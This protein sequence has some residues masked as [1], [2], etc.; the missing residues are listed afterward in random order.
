MTGPDGELAWV[1]KMYRWLIEEDLSFREIADRLNEE[2]AT[3]DLDRPWNSSTVRTILSNEK[4]IGNN[5][6]SFKLKKLH[7]ENPLDMWVRK[8]GAFAG[9]VPLEIYLTARME[10]DAIRSYVTRH[11]SEFL[12]QFDLV[13]NTVSME[14]A[15]ER[16]ER[17]DGPSATQATVE[18][19]LAK[20]DSDD[21]ISDQEWM[22]HSGDGLAPR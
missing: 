14:E 18:A 5:R 20:G 3:T 11:A 2:G 19:Q 8:E 15:V 9:T 12:E 21:G 13:L 17:E 4:Y 7:V 16:S 1:N 10:S 6:S 22:A